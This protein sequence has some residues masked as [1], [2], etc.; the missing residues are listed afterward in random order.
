MHFTRDGQTI[1][2]SDKFGDIFRYV[3]SSRNSLLQVLIFREAIP[4]TLHQQN[5]LLRL[6]LRSPNPPKSATQSCRTKTRP[7]APSSSDTPLF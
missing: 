3:G 4:F 5:L 7:T 2:V 6:S 1:L